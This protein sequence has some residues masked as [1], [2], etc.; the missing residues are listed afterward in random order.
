MQQP[1]FEHHV[2]RWRSKALAVSRACG[3]LAAEADDVAQE[4][5]LKLWMMR[6]ELERYRSIEALVSVMSRNLTIGHLRRRMLERFMSGESSLDEEQM[7]SRYF[8]T[9]EVDEAWKPYQQMFAYFDAGMPTDSGSI[10][11]TA[12]R[13]RRRRWLYW[14]AA[15][16]T[17]A[18]MLTV[19]WRMLNA[20]QAPT[21]AQSDTTS[22][23]A[24]VTPP[25][26]QA[27]S[28]V[29]TEPTTTPE[30]VESASIAT[31]KPRKS[32]TKQHLA[33]HQRR[34]DSLEV[35][36]TQAELEIAEQEVIADRILLEQELRQKQPAASGWVTTSLNIQ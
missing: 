17:V 15:A 5:L 32:A 8:A 7:L 36:H 30:K 12:P 1:E 28:P 22:M 26:P 2:P 35:T 18:L 14:S 6:D 21:V 25:Q 23:V 13:H 11:S 24:V 20:P 3:A 4:V 33:A 31:T 9:H 27:S 29:T 34:G 16:A 19:G 10:A